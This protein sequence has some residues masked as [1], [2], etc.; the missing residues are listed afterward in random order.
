MYR[1]IYRRGKNNENG[2]VVFRLTGLLLAASL[3][4]GLWSTPAGAEV[5]D[6]FATQGTLTIDSGAGLMTYDDGNAL[7]PNLEFTAVKTATLSTWTFGD[8]TIGSGVTVSLTPGSTRRRGIKLVADGTGETGLGNILID[9]NLTLSG[10][11]ASGTNNAN[12]G[13]A[14][15]G[16]GTGGTDG[17]SGTNRKGVSG[18]TWTRGGTGAGAGSVTWGGGGGGFGGDGGNGQGDTGGPF[19]GGDAYGRLDLADLGAD[20]GPS[21][22][23]GGGAGQRGGGGAG[24]GAI[25]LVAVNDVTIASGRTISAKGGQGKSGTTTNKNRTGGGGS[26][27][28]ILIIADSDANGSGTAAYSGATLNVNGG[29][30]ARS[31][32]AT[33]RGGG[34]GGGRIVVSGAEVVA[35]TNSG[36]GGSTG[37]KGSNGKQGS[38]YSEELDGVLN[39]SGNGVAAP[40][41]DSYASLTVS[42]TSTLSI[43]N[44]I[45]TITVD[46]NA[47][48]NGGMDVEL[49]GNGGGSADL[50]IVTGELDISNANTTVNFSIIGDPLDDLAYVFATYGTLVGDPFATINLPAE[51]PN[52][53]IDYNY[54]GGNQIALVIPEPTT[55]GLLAIGG[56]LTALRRRRR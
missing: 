43:G 18:L 19:A 8:L 22:G 46:G 21:G 40:R 12:G 56:L 55:L 32:V 3:A 11:G 17:T 45:G 42:T 44:S 16:G 53:T 37:T 52:A 20:G 25:Q 50:L 33:E 28:A 7:T 30:S 27:G 48:V 35:G 9:K 24:G 1:R 34:G 36:A 47:D 38:L 13:A 31:G 23:S 26:G 5:V 14:A 41:Y 51:F 29:D 10:A 49:D 4:G 6:L 15:Y 54:E 39:L 2:R